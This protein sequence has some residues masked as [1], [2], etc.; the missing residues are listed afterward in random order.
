M[1]RF[2]NFN[3]QLPGKKLAIVFVC[4]LV[5]LLGSNFST[6]QNSRFNPDI[7]GSWVS[8]D[9]PKSKFVFT[10]DFKC[11][12]YYDGEFVR[13]Q[14]YSIS[15]S[16][17]ECGSGGTATGNTSYVTLTSITNSAVTSCYEIMNLQTNVLSLR[18]VDR[19]TPILF[20]KEG[21]PSLKELEWDS[22]NQ[23]KLFDSPSLGIRSLWGNSFHDDG[24]TPLREAYGV[25]VWD[26]DGNS[27]FFAYPLGLSTPRHPNGFTDLPF[28]E[29]EGK[30]YIEYDG[31]FYQVRALFH[32]HP[33]PSVPYIGPYEGY[34]GPDDWTFLRSLTS[35]GA[36]IKGVVITNQNVY[37]Y[38]FTNG[39]KV[40]FN[41]IDRKSYFD[42]RCTANL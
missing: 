39:N 7:A 6:K 37:S 21:T 23:Y 36:D 42:G 14:I 16:T 32:T 29:E 3:I 35:S 24:K 33:D 18:P 5:F 2:K 19:Y 8:E 38:G 30:V 28:Y 4:C 25:L 10:N 31:Q 34:F 11:H 22:E 27:K 17:P 26:V 20:H 41:T 13:T 9:D 12:E 40:I 1:N 15:N